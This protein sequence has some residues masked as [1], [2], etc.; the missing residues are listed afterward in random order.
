MFQGEYT[1]EDNRCIFE[2]MVKRLV[3]QDPGLG[4]LAEV[5]H[6]IDLKESKYNRGH[7]EGL[8]AML[9]GL[10]ASEPD[11]EKPMTRGAQLIDNLYTFF[12]EQKD[13]KCK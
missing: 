1:I 9:T 5:N 8:G 12:Q 11:D 6:D 3:P 13:L 2:M 10:A 4:D 7:T